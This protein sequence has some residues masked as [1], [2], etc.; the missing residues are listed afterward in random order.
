MIAGNT[1]LWGP[2]TVRAENIM[3]NPKGIIVSHTVA[4]DGGNLSISG[5]I[6]SAI[7]KKHLLYW[8][9]ISYPMVNGMGPNLDVLPELEYLK[10]QGI[11]YVDNISI[12]PTGIIPGCENKNSSIS[13]QY[14]PDLLAHGQLQLAQDKLLKSEVWGVAQVGGTLS[15]SSQDKTSK[16]MLELS[17][18]DGLPVPTDQTSFD[19]VI[20]F[21]ISHTKELNNLREVLEKFREQIVS[22]TDSGR[23]LVLLKE[24]LS[25]SISNINDSMNKHKIENFFDTLSVYLNVSA[26]QLTAT[27]LGVLLATNAGAPITLGA[28]IGMGVNTILKAIEREVRGAGIVPEEINDYM[29]LYSAQKHGIV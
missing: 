24:E 1:P 3:P 15:F 21:R 14:I 26:N 8:D 7:L 17:L 27:G 16:N 25:D 10:S 4:R 20:N 13:M 2:L 12:D 29:Y 23:T 19:D 6:D 18:F 5:G 11:L 9:L 28:S 22:S